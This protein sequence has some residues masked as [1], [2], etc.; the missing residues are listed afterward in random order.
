MKK[1]DLDGVLPKLTKMANI[2]QEIGETADLIV[3][4]TLYTYG[5][6]GCGVFKRGIQNY[7]DFCIKINILK[8]NY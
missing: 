3:V 1:M 8:G 4:S 2:S 6:M 5:N 7:K